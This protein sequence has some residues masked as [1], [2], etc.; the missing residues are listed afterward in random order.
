MSGNFAY[1]LYY[2]FLRRRQGRA[3]AFFVLGFFVLPVCACNELKALHR[4]G[5]HHV[6]SWATIN[7]KIQITDDGNSFLYGMNMSRNWI[8]NEFHKQGS[9][10]IKK[11][12]ENH[13]SVLLS[14]KNIKWW[15]L[16]KKC[17]LH[18]AL[19][20]KYKKIANLFSQCMRYY[21]FVFKQL[22]FFKCLKN[23]LV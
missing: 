21:L 20:L 10:Q 18:T 5:C 9:I 23:N 13:N 22:L 12:N 15:I 4:G 19:K 6:K 2:S 16:N 3:Y 14:W 17:T 11:V 8:W 1:Q 7:I